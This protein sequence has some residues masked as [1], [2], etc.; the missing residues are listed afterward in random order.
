[1]LVL[2]ALFMTFCY[3]RVAMTLFASRRMLE[4][5]ALCQ[6]SET[7]KLSEKK[8]EKKK[9]EKK[10]KKTKRDFSSRTGSIMHQTRKRV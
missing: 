3:L 6:A 9:K 1:M 2:P 4:A 10:E 7:S 5:F 8:K